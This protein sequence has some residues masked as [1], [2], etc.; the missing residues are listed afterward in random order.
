MIESLIEGPVAETTSEAEALIREAR[1]RQHRRR[2]V[3]GVSVAAVILVLGACSYF[4]ANHAGGSRSAGREP[5]TRAVAAGAFAGTW[6]VHTYSLTVRADG[7]G[8]F[9][10]PTHNP[11]AGPG[12]APG[13]CDSLVPKT[14]DSAG[15]RITIDEIIDGGHARLEL[16]S[17]A[18]RTAKGRI[19]GSTEQS[20]LPDGPVTLRVTADDVLRVTTAIKPAM[21]SF[22]ALCGSKAAALSG[23][24]QRAEGINCGA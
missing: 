13:A 19:T 23:P 4:V 7:H 24:R 10:W 14:V 3:I 8:A 9:E 6:H 15:R 2:R 22:E 12:A 16:I 11:C 21:P 5:G 18:G 20:V 1:A 17:V